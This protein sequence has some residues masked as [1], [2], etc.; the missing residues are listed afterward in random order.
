MRDMI[1][2]LGRVLM[3]A[4]FIQAGLSELIH[5]GGTVGYFEAL[6]LPFP[7]ITV[8]GVLAIEI[9]G[10]LALLLGY[11]MRVAASILGLFAIA[12]GLIGHSNIGDTTQLQMLMKDIAIGGGLFYMAIH[13][14][15]LIS[16][17]ASREA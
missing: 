14:A 7:W 9:L 17:D 4:L 8:W 1:M 2:V 6:G 10:G 12:A 15:G 11:R 16:F 3:S 13:G 5:L